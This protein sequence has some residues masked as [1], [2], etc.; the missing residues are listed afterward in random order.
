MNTILKSIQTD[1]PYKEW[2]R[3]ENEGRMK[4]QL[5]DLCTNAEIFR[6]TFSRET[7]EFINHVKRLREQYEVMTKLKENLR[8]HEIIVQMDY[9]MNYTCRM[10]DETQDADWDQTGVTLNP[11]VVYFTVI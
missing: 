9:A 1:I 7:G 10:M 8:G 5:V 3:V 11:V 2:K 4:V 6:E